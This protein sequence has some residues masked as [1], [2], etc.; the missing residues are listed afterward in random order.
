[1]K[2]KHI[3]LSISC[4]TVFACSTESVTPTEEENDST[5]LRKI[6]YDKDTDNESTILFNYDGNK[7]ISKDYGDNYTIEYIYENNK[8]VRINDFDGNDDLHAFITIEYNLDEKLGSYIIF[9]EKDN[10]HA[11]KHIFT[12]NSDNTMTESVYYGTYAAQETLLYISTN[13]FEGRNIINEKWDDDSVE[14][15]YTYDNEKG[16]LRNIEH[17]DIINLISI[18]FGGLADLGSINNV[19]SIKEIQEGTVNYFDEYEYIYDDN[20]YPKSS[21]YTT[22]SRWGP[23]ED[24][25]MDFFYE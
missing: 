19:T 21:I 2:F 1:M 24:T 12:H 8:L 3:L 11:E 6:I 5:L 22:E 4:I 17:I 15:V 9:F 20:G 7:L 25:T 13:T 23:E 18:D 16:V 10:D 14:Y